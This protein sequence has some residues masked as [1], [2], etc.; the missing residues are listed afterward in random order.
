M[1][2]AGISCL[3][4]RNRALIWSASH[5]VTLSTGVCVAHVQPAQTPVASEDTQAIVV[6]GI[7]N[8]LQDSI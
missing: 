6:T 1:T 2:G 7:R 3:T 5:I 8:G 4:A